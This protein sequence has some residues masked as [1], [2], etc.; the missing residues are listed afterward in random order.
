MPALLDFAT[1]HLYEEILKLRMKNWAFWISNSEPI[2]ISK[3]QSSFPDVWLG[4]V[5]PYSDMIIRDFVF[6]FL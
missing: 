4:L 3:D 5:Y 6:D 2:T 1:L